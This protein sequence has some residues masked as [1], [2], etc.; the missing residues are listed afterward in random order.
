MKT[1]NPNLP[2]LL[3][4][5]FMSLFASSLFT[6]VA[7]L[8]VLTS[9]GSGFQFALV[10]LAGTLPRV[11][12]SPFAG[13]YADRLNRKRLIISMESLNGLLFL[14]AGFASLMWTFGAPTFLLIT[15]ILSVFST[16]LSVTISSSIPLLFEE[17]ELQRV[18]SLIQSI[19]SFSSIGTPLLAGALFKL[20]PI[21]A[22]LFSSAVLFGIAALLATRLKFNEK[23]VTAPTQAAWKD[24]KS[25]FNYLKNK[26]VL[27]TLTILA[28]FLNFFFVASEVLFPIVTLQ[29]I[30]VSPLQFGF[31]QSMFAVGFLVASLLHALPFFKIKYQLTTSLRSL[32]ALSVIFISPA[33]PVLLGFSVLASMIFLTTFALLTG[34]LVIRTNIPLQIYLQSNTDP[35]YLGRVM[36]VLESLAMGMT[37]FGFILFGMLSELVPASA[38]YAVC[39]VCQLSLTLFSMYRIREDIRAEKNAPMPEADVSVS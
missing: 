19:I 22:F 26:R 16:F 11:L 39:M 10:L 29:T 30:G 31:L 1:K 25:G 28:A 35:K 5:K 8:I 13:A 2:V 34:F 4:G 36:G 12:L 37:P 23:E 38:L 14:I 6:F 9:S 7:G 20:L 32:T 33:I 21:S 15:A 18:N 27:W 17:D 24:V 3:L